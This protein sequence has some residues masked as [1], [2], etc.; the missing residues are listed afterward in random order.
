MLIPKYLKAQDYIPFLNRKRAWLIFFFVFFI[1]W[2]SVF[3]IGFFVFILLGILLFSDWV[4]LF[5]GLAFLSMA[6]AALSSVAFI[7]CIARYKRY[8][9]FLLVTFFGASLL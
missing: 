7:L 8:F 1:V 4:G 5:I 9:L 2:M 3:Y 6:L